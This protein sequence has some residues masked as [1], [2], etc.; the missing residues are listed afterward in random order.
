M[1]QHGDEHRWHPVESCDLFLIDAGK[2]LFRGKSGDGRHGDSVCHG[3]R[4]GQNHPKAVKHGHLYHHPVRRREVHTVSDRLS[5]IDDIVVRQHN[6]LGESCG[7]GRILH[8]ADI[9][10]IDHARA[11]VN[12]LHGNFLRQL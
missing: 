12:L 7:P 10:F 2:P 6:P 9:M 5:I 8:I 1:A 3:G 4:H 11:A